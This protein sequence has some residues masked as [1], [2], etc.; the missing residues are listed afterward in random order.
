MPG[1]PSSV[2]APRLM[3]FVKFVNSFLLDE[4]IAFK[5]LVGALNKFIRD[6]GAE[7][8]NWEELVCGGAS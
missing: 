2:L 3:K 6:T 1:A 7:R 4:L 5:A 8:A